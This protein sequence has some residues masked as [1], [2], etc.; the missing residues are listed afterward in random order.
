MKSLWKKMIQHNSRQEGDRKWRVIDGK[1]L[2]I[3]NHCVHT[4]THDINRSS[5]LYV[6]NFP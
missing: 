3:I 4:E 1:K 2:V 5:F 6:C